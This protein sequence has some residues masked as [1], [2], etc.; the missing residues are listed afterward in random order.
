MESVSHFLTQRGARRRDLALRRIAFLLCFVFTL[1]SLLFSLKYRS[2]E[3]SLLCAVTPLLLC[4]PAFAERLLSKRMH[5][6]VYLLCLCYALGP[7]LG[8][9][10]RLYYSTLWWD[11][12]LHLTG[13]LVFALVGSQMP[14]LLGQ[15]EENPALELFCAFFFSVALAALWEF[16]EYGVDCLFG[17]D[18][19]HDRFV[20]ALHSY[21]LGPSLGE[22]GHIENIQSVIV[23]GQSMAGYL[24]IGLH[25]TMG[26]M[27]QE[28][29][30]ALL[31]SLALLLDRGRH[32]LFIPPRERIEISA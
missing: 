27:L 22:L 18:M 30:G 11:K 32:P 3:S 14:A 28:R 8:Q 7:M 4:L 21:T 20:S 13:G 5:T 6:A 29:L 12:L 26:D 2:T 19:Q 15:R 25:D 10:Y 24:D 31:F 9:T 1:G 23:N 16:F 17:M